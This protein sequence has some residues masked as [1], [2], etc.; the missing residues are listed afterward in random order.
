MILLDDQLKQEPQDLNKIVMEADFDATV[1]LKAIGVGGC[2]CNSINRMIQKEVRGVD[3]LTINTD[4]KD[5]Q[6]NYSPKKIH[7]MGNTLKGLGT[8]GDPELA[9]KA[10]LDAADQIREELKDT[11]MVFLTAG[12]G[13][14]TG[15]GATGIVASICKEMDILTLAF[16]ITPFEWEGVERLKRSEEGLKSIKENV[17]S[18]IIIP[19]EKLSKLVDPNTHAVTAFDLADEILINAVQGVSAIV[20][21]TGYKNIDFADIQAALKNKGKAII[22]MGT[23]EGEDAA[24]KAAQKAISS[25]LLEET[26]ISGASNVLFCFTGNPKNAKFKDF[27]N[28]GR[29]IAEMVSDGG[30]KPAEINFGIYYDSNLPEN[31]VRV[32]I[33]A[34]GFEKANQ[35]PVYKKPEIFQSKSPSIVETNKTQNPYSTGKENSSLISEFFGENASDKNKPS[36]YRYKKD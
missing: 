19:N 30:R 16:I 7:L 14:G 32:I 23:E 22:G 24:M 36:Y 26:S 15:S 2:G 3:F 11:K 12:L 35:E 34:T 17:D 8:G 13:G 20:N 21:N 9:R 10:A 31:A 4:F 6:K 25:P 33:F 29:K 5:L 18:L 28:M 27:D 1:K